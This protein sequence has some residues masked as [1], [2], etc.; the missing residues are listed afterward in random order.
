MNKIFAFMGTLAKLAIE[1]GYVFKTYAKDNAT[2]YIELG[3]YE[4]TI[5]VH[6]DIS[7]KRIVAQD[8]DVFDMAEMLFKEMEGKLKG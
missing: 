3:I 1:K 2:L 7:H 5:E 8:S 4:S 6:V